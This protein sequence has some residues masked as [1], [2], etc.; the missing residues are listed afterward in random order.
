MQLL[1]LLDKYRS[2]DGSYDCIVPG[3]GGKDSCFAA[4][5]LKYKYGMNP[6]TV[7]WRPHIY[8]PWGQN[9]FDNWINSGFA[10]V[11]I[12]S[13]P[14]THRL[15]SRLA[16][17]NL[18]HPFQTF[19]LGQFSMPAK[20]AMRFGI[21]LVIY[22]EDGAEYGNSAST[23]FNPQKSTTSSTPTTFNSADSSDIFLAGLPIET[24]QNDFQIPKSD[25]DHYLPPNSEDV[26]NAGTFI[27]KLGYYIPW[28][29]QGSF[30]YA[31]KNCGFKPAPERTQG[32]YTKFN[33]IDDKLDDLFYWTGY[34]KFCQ[35]RATL[36]ACQDIYSGEITRSE[37]VSLV[38]KY[39]GEYPARFE[40]EVFNYLSL[41]DH[42]NYHLFDS[43]L[44][45]LTRDYLFSLADNFRSPHL[46]DQNT[47]NTWTPKHIVTDNSLQDNVQD[48]MKWQGNSFNYTNKAV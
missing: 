5:I 1:D 36:D 40:T 24:L 15:L 17:E 47:D 35:G 45:R 38:K 43:L 23:I 25:L 9:N 21:Q 42:P 26:D 46:W 20:L 2:K 39:D 4:H 18:F 29:P 41:D 27:A 34:I 44:P 28:R 48:I 6:L 33:S 30:E 37:A 8:T 10:N 7:T 11:S 3:S 22:G 32:T 12:N 13:N 16:L 14:Y 31:A 19:G